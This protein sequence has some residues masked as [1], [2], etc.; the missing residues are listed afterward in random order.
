MYIR[1]GRKG[2]GAMEGLAGAWRGHFLLLPV[3]T[4]LYYFVA[5]VK[6]LEHLIADKCILRMDIVCRDLQIQ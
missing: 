5:C 1:K 4:K 2:M 3:R 6:R